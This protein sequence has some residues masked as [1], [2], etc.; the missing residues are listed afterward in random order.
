M[1]IEAS[2]QNGADSPPTHL[3]VDDTK[4]Y[5]VKWIREIRP[6]DGDADDRHGWLCV[7]IDA[8]S[9]EYDETLSASFVVPPSDTD[10]RRP[11]WPLLQAVTT[12]EMAP[13]NRLE[14][15]TASS[16]ARSRTRSAQTESVAELIH[17][18]RWRRASCL[19]CGE[20]I[21]RAR[22]A[23]CM[24]AGTLDGS[25]LAHWPSSP[26]SMATSGPVPRDRNLYLLG[27][28]HR[29][30]LSLV[31][32]RVRAG[33]ACSDTEL[34]LLSIEESTDLDYM[35]HLPADESTCPFCGDP[36]PLT[37]EHV[38]PR[39]LS[40]ELRRLGGTFLPRAGETRAPRSIDATVG[41]CRRCNND[42]LSTLENDVSTIAR[43]MLRGEFV[44]LD[45]ERQ[46]LLATW[47]TKTAYM[48]DRLTEPTVPR[49][50]PMELLIRRQPSTSTLVFL[51]AYDGSSAAFASFR[52]LPA[53][54]AKEALPSESN[55]YVAT[56]TAHKLAF[57][58]I[59]H[60]TRGVMA[61]NDERL[62]L[63][64]GLVQIWGSSDLGVSWVC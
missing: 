8:Y 34:P 39:W 48:I 27:A 15:S 36:G 10:P 53:N 54:T 63:H 14:E 45:T 32:Q 43:P 49:G 51:S 12:K 56:F 30:C 58:V 64:D 17:T 35:L 21:V 37:D 18:P 38:W 41:V 24:L 42:W 40:K 11:N 31:A 20:L 22:D 62:G 3:R 5:Q 29:S 23:H 59:G 16:A 1:K 26:D 7:A 6:V 47:A 2:F 25:W 4:T 50:F 33:L 57:Q 19:A 55:A 28:C 61:I 52:P 46:T 60:F 13:K 44:Y 9:N